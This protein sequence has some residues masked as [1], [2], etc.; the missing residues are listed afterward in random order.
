MGVAWPR[1]PH[2]SGPGGQ[3]L[4]WSLAVGPQ[5]LREGRP[6]PRCQG[7]PHAHCPA[8]PQPHKVGVFVLVP[9][10]EMMP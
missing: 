8:R 4:E 6:M 3:E 2:L 7:P 1:G 5:D 10:S 9:R